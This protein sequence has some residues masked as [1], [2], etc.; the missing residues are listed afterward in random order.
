MTSLGWGGVGGK[1]LIGGSDDD[2]TTATPPQ[3]QQKQDAQPETPSWATPPV[4]APTPSGKATK[5]KGKGKQEKQGQQRPEGDAPPV[6]PVASQTVDGVEPGPS[7]RQLNTRLDDVARREAA[8]R[9]REEH[10]KEL[11]DRLR[12]GG[13]QVK[14]KNCEFRRPPPAHLILTNWLTDRAIALTTAT[15]LQGQSANPFCTTTSML[16]SPPPTNRFARR[17]TTAG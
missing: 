3:A 7:Q 2:S 12:E 16:R 1:S 6:D 13:I 4:P 11:E 10:I 14:P 5:G 15:A 17:A 8:V 9:Q